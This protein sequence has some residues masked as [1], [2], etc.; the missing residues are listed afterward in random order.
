M[1]LRGLRSI[2][3]GED[4]M[5]LLT[6]AGVPPSVPYVVLAPGAGAPNR[7]WPASSFCELCKLILDET[8][9]NVV[10]AGTQAEF[11]L[12]DTI[13][14]GSKGR[15]FNCTGKFSLAAL[16]GVLA[17][18]RAFVGNDSG[19]GHIAGPLG[20]PVISLHTQAEGADPCHIR[21]P[22]RQRPLGPKVSV[23]RPP[24]FLHPCR[25][26]CEAA[27]AHC[28]SQITPAS[29]FNE[30]MRALNMESTQ[31]SSGNRQNDGEPLYQVVVV[32]R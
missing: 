2:A 28:I 22:E 14:T 11:E 7:A 32:S 21:A 18:A 6:K 4:A 12:G 31:R 8:D 17:H 23:L 30:L 25:T 9:F 26:H 5:G 19:T 29:V 13:A 24:S 1:Q 10:I 3:K 27:G 16:T 15:V 20:I